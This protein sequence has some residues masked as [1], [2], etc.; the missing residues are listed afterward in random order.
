MKIAL[1]DEKVQH[2]ED[3]ENSSEDQEQQ[4]DEVAEKVDGLL[5]FQLNLP[6]AKTKI[7]DF[8]EA[9]RGINS[10]QPKQVLQQL[11]NYFHSDASW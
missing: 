9:M 5:Q 7:S 6:L 3:S 10:D 4:T 2:G 1:L 8:F 11:K